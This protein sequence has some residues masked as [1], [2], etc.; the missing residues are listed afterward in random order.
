M[1]VFSAE[2]DSVA[3]QLVCVVRLVL[4]AGCGFCIGIE[5]TNRLKDAGMRTHLIVCMSAAL[6]MVVSKYGFF[7]IIGYSDI[8][9][10]DPGRIA[11]SIVSGVSFLGAG[12]IFVRNRSITGLTTAAGIWATAGIGMAM[13]AGM[14]LI[15]LAGTGLLIGAQG[16]LHNEHIIG[17]GIM[18][19]TLRIDSRCGTVSQTVEKLQSIG[20]ELVNLDVSQKKNDIIKIEMRIKPGRNIDQ[21]SVIRELETLPWVLEVSE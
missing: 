12:I 13:G 8:Y 14:Y 2:L 4:A 18:A 21:L 5:R 19:L 9:K 3:F 10:L 15:A 17:G 1:R 20:A 6:M 7:D 16:L 11:S